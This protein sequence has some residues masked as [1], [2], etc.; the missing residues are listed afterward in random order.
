V[1]TIDGNIFYGENLPDNV[2]YVTIC[3]DKVVFRSRYLL[4]VWG[5]HGVF[6]CEEWRELF[7]TEKKGMVICAYVY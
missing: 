1:V 6:G 4:A 2:L 7:L 3:S 5:I